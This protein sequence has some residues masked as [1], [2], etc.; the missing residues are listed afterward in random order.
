MTDANLTAF[1]GRANSRLPPEVNRILFVRN[2][3]FKITTEELYDLFGRYGAIRQIRKGNTKDT[4]GT[5]FVV[6]EDIYDAKTACDSLSGFHVLDRYLIVLYYQPA[7]KNKK[8]DLTESK[9]EIEKM[10]TKYGVKGFKDESHG[11][12]WGR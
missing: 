6:Y 5:A 1:R 7:K 11:V 8:G 12:K 9:S 10:K 2:L 3:P 4:R